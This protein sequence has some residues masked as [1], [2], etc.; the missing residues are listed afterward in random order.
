MPREMFD[1]QKT[2]GYFSLLSRRRHRITILAN[3]KQN[4]LFV[5]CRS[6]QSWRGKKSSL[7]ELSGERKEKNDRET[8]EY[9]NQRVESFHVLDYQ[10][11]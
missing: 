2:S 10:M 9:Q 1:V 6:S 11:K 7:S 8:K 3:Y 5:S 4:H